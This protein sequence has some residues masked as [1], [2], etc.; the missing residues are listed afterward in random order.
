MEEITVEKIKE[1]IRDNLRKAKEQ[2]FPEK[3]N[4]LTEKVELKLVNSFN[5]TIKGEIIELGLKYKHL[6]KKIPLLN[7]VAKKSYHFMRNNFVYQK[8]ELI[9]VSERLK[10]THQRIDSPS[11]IMNRTIKS[12]N[13][14]IPEII[15]IDN[16]N[17]CF[18]PTFYKNWDMS[19][20]M[21]FILNHFDNTAW[22]LDVGCTS[23]PLLFNLAEKGYLNLYGIDLHLPQQDTY[24]HPQIRYIEAD[25]TQTPFKDCQFDCI[26]SLSVIEHGVNPKNY[27]KEMARILKYGGILLTSTDYWPEKIQTKDV[28]HSMTFG[29][30]WNIFSKM[31]ITELIHI[32]ERYG[33]KLL[34]PL[35]YTTIEPVVHYLSKAYT[36]FAFGMKKQ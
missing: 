33:F 36:F 28:P 2:N 22:T 17:A 16:L 21:C 12:L 34:T 4:E 26:T 1:R 32:S 29:L 5:Q 8:S 27:F 18:H 15:F 30:P 25:L 7:A 3:A 11:G 10:P 14:I 9:Q 13:D 20:F 35:E 23:N 24:I 19:L 6:I 31:E